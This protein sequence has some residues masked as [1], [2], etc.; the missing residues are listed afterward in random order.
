MSSSEG[1]AGTTSCMDA[2][3]CSMMWTPSSTSSSLV[4]T[5]FSKGS[6]ATGSSLSESISMERLSRSARL[7][8]SSDALDAASTWTPCSHAASR[9]VFSQQ[10]MILSRLSSMYAM[11]A[12]AHM[13]MFFFMVGRLRSRKM[14]QLATPLFSWSSTWVSDQEEKRRRIS[15]LIMAMMPA[16]MGC[17]TGV[18]DAGTYTTRIHG[19][20]R[21]RCALNEGQSQPHHILQG[22]GGGG[23]QHLVR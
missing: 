8:K 22:R 12:L 13:T 10:W 9:P 20:V 23:S 19:Y 6:L 21:R 5:S 2:E 15:P 14:S 3:A 16:S 11:A 1:S 7:G 17:P 4:M 18:H